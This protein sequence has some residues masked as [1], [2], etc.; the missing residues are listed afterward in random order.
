[1]T[2]NNTWEGV[3]GEEHRGD[4]MV[5]PT[6]VIDNY[7]KPTESVPQRSVREV[8][9]PTPSAMQCPTDGIAPPTLVLAIGLLPSLLRVMVQTTKLPNEEAQRVD[10]RLMT[11]AAIAG[12]LFDGDANARAQERH[13]RCESQR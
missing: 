12:Y 7:I 11:T 6:S 2:C 8:M 9:Y 1:M 10:R 3:W 5:V 4:D 13:H